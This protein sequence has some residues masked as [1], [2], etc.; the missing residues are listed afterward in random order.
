MAN[1]I[2]QVTFSKTHT[3]VYKEGIIGIG[4]VVCYGHCSGM[5]KLVACSAHKKIKGIFMIQRGKR[6]VLQ[7]VF[8]F[9]LDPEALW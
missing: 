7:T 5:G 9:D 2:E 8:C 3:A 1:G 4:R 6:Y